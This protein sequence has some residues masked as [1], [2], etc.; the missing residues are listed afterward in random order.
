M[1]NTSKSKSYTNQ[2]KTNATH[3]KNLHKNHT[4]NQTQ[5]FAKP[6]KNQTQHLTKHTNSWA[7]PYKNCTIFL[8]MTQQNHTR[9]PHKI[10]QNSHNTYTILTHN[11]IKQNATKIFLKPFAHTY[12]D[13]HKFLQNHEQNHTN[14][15]NK[16]Q[17][18][19]TFQ[20]KSYKNITQIF[21]KSKTESHKNS[22]AE[23]CKNPKHKIP[24]KK[25]AK[26]MQ[27]YKTI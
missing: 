5:H 1:I 4:Q 27:K 26:T 10:K 25:F 22:Y 19:Y 11:L 17:I 16:N 14:I 21:T 15:L 6:N 9:I 8:H 7:K 23:S 12:K 24:H 2:T 13:L 18:L 20:T 3:S